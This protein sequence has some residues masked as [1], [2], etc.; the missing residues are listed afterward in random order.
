MNLVKVIRQYYAERPR[1]A[2][3]SDQV[4]RLLVTSGLLQ[5]QPPLDAVFKAT[6]RLVE[7]GHLSQR[8][9]PDDGS[10]VYQATPVGIAAH[11]A[12]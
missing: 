6:R 5:E 7:L 1:G 4:Q 12:T 2:F 3:T 9:D 8:T 11:Q 10:T